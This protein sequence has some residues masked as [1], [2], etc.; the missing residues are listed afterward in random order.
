MLLLLLCLLQEGHSVHGEAF[1][2]GPR[3]A[4]VRMAGMGDVRFAVTTEKEDAQAFV[5]QGV[6][7]LH[8]FYYFEAE[9][10]FR[11]AAAIDPGCA[12]AYWGMALA[13]IN[14]DKRAKG[15]IEEA[16]KR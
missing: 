14:N 2:E 16:V 10:S 15:F 8:G 4:A 7:Q 1:N 3:Q 11:Q 13:N 6:A 5:N 9:R 12:M